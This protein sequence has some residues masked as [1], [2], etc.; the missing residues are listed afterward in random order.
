MYTI[1]CLDN[2]LS[3][4]YSREPDLIFPLYS[5]ANDFVLKHKF[6]EFTFVVLIVFLRRKLGFRF[7]NLFVRFQ[8]FRYS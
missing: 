4:H 1:S 6:Y 7:M 5:K 8:Y 2:N 3:D